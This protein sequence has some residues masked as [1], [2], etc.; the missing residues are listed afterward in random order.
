MVP[1]LLML[2]NEQSN[3]NA[4]R[5]IITPKVSLGNEHRQHFHTN[6]FAIARP[7]SLS[8][9]KRLKRHVDPALQLLQPRRC[10]LRAHRAATLAIRHFL[11][12]L[13]LMLPWLRCLISM[14]CKHC[15]AFLLRILLL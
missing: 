9:S 4:A 15:S 11:G 1:T 8:S 12:E 6:N 5:L 10:P 7:R 13:L 2:I 3:M 14:L